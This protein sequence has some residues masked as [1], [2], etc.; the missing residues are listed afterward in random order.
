M[1][2][3]TISHYHGAVSATATI[4]TPSTAE[5][6]LPKI[7]RRPGAG[8]SFTQSLIRFLDSNH[9]IVPFPHFFIALFA[10]D[11]SYHPTGMTFPHDFG[12]TPG[13]RHLSD[14]M[15]AAP[16]EYSLHLPHS[17]QDFLAIE[18]DGSFLVGLAE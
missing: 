6:Q 16:S 5:A 12:F 17:R 3:Q 18:I 2:G 4:S 15:R 10:F 8:P 14:P 11:D 9:T 13:S 1:I 7:Q